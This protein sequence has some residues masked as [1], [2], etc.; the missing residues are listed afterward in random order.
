M[1]FHGLISVIAMSRMLTGAMPPVDPLKSQMLELPAFSVP[2]P[3]TFAGSWRNAT[4]LWVQDGRWSFGQPERGLG[5]QCVLTVVISSS[6]RLRMLENKSAIINFRFPGGRVR[7]YPQMVA[8]ELGGGGLYFWTQQFG[9]ALIA[10]ERPREA[11]FAFALENPVKGSWERG[12]PLV[13]V[14]ASGFESLTGTRLSRMWCQGEF[15]RLERLQRVFETPGNI[16]SGL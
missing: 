14:E 7:L 9:V 11:S 15:L 8:G 2:R 13:T 12:I 6:D 16:I 3:E 10:P 4:E 5:T 1:L